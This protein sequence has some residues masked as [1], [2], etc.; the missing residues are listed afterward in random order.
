LVLDA[1]EYIFALG[2]DREPAPERLLATV[3]SQGD[4]VRIERTIVQEV[5]R[6]L[7]GHDLRDFFAALDDLLEE[8]CGIDEDFVVPHHVAQHYQDVGFK[9]AD[10]HIAAYAHVVEA[11]AI[12]TE[13]RRHFH[14]LA[15]HLPF[16]VMDAEQFLKRHAAG[17]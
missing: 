11:E 7:S 16:K 1:N 2:P 4:V 9:E 5:A 15:G 12:V 14:T 3:Q 13:N 8:G 10:A 6:H 17:R